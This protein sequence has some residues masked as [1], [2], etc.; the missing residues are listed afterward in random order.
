M[1]F[2][3]LTTTTLF[4]L[5]STTLLANA[6]PE[7]DYPTKPDY[8]T[9]PDPPKEQCVTCNPLSGE[10]HCDQTTSCI[11]TGTQFY[12]ACRAGYKAS[13][14]ESDSDKQFRLPFKNYEFLV[15]VP[16]YQECN[17]LCDDYTLPP[18]KLC[19]EVQLQEQCTVF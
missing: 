14:N 13:E 15:F 19:S 18:P 4:I 11:S 8:P 10:N 12:C 3:S 7:P 17:T 9:D 2:K 16:P 5:A 1:I 6:L